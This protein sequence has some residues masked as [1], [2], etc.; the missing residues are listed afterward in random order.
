MTK[1]TLPSGFLS[2]LSYS[3]RILPSRRHELEA[4]GA[5]VGNENVSSLGK[6]ETVRQRAEEQALFA[7]HRKSK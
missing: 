4:I 2:R 7:V 3:V 1:L 5:E 6:G